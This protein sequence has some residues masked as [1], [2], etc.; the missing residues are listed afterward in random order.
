MNA[1]QLR[2]A[3][4]IARHIREQALEPALNDCR[5]IEAFY[6]NYQVEQDIEFYPVERMALR[7]QQ[8]IVGHVATEMGTILRDMLPSLASQNDDKEITKNER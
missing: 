8:E 6:E 3:A 5:S 7:L 4:S 1:A 2:H